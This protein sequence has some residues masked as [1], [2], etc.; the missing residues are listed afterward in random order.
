MT[1]C[2]T[3]LML[4][5]SLEDRFGTCGLA[6]LPTIT[7]TCAAPLLADAHVLLAA[8]ARLARRA[9]APPMGLQDRTA[10]VLA[11]EQAANHAQRHMLLTRTGR[12]IAYP[13]PVWMAALLVAAAAWLTRRYSPA[14][15]EEAVTSREQQQQQQQQQRA[16][17][18]R[19]AA[20]AEGPAAVPVRSQPAAPQAYAG[21]GMWTRADELQALRQENRR[22]QA[23]LEQALS[24]KADMQQQAAANSDR[25]DVVMQTNAQLQAS[26]VQERAI[27]Y[28]AQRICDALAEVRGAR[29]GSSGARTRARGRHTPCEA[30]K[31]THACTLAHLHAQ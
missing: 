22:L 30:H 15:A 2:R 19:H 11:V 21:A 31:L 4:A 7:S 8:Q 25:V 18:E 14:A 13:T 10:E 20:A 24:E 16:P 1:Q 27:A 9:E 3:W 29:N 26:L 6:P 12:A 17:T 28:R 5:P 23:A